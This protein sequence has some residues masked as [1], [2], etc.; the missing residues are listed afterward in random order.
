MIRMIVSE[1]VPRDEIA[2]VNLIREPG[3]HPRIEVSKIVN[4]ATGGAMRTESEIREK[5]AQ[6]EQSAW[7]YSS[8]TP[9]TTDDERKMIAVNAL[10]WVLGEAGEL[11]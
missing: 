8:G 10:R 5:A 9:I 2:F 11:L 4:V 6:L 3:N 7:Q 1:A